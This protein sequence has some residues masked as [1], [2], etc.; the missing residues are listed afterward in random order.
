MTVEEA[1]HRRNA[2]FVLSGNPRDWVH[3]RNRHPGVRDVALGTFPPMRGAM[4]DLLGFLTEISQSL[5]QQ[6]LVAVEVAVQHEPAEQVSGER[7]GWHY[8]V[9]VLAVPMTVLLI[10]EHRF[11]EM[12]AK[13][14]ESERKPG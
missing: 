5:K 11:E 7:Q 1:E 10:E 12:R 3:Y 13:L 4:A 8:R 6:Q 14:A 2:S 9:E